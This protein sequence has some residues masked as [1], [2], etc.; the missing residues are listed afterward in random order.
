[1]PWDKEEILFA[2]GGAVIQEGKQ[3]AFGEIVI[4]SEKVERGSVYV[5]LTG[6][7]FEGHDFL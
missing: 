2:T 4:D 5:A 6:A 3:P 7:M 1:M